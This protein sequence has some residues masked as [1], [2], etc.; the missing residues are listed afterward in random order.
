MNYKFKCVNVKKETY[1]RLLKRKIIP[2]ET[3]DSVINR[4]LDGEKDEQ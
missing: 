1:E 4:I 3:M 2:R